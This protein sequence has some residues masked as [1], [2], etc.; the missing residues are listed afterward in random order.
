MINLNNLKVFF[1]ADV[2]QP[3]TEQDIPDQLV[4]RLTEERYVNS[5]ICIEI[6]KIHSLFS[7]VKNTK[8]MLLNF[9]G[10]KKKKKTLNFLSNMGFFFFL[11]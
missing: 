9:V 10:L 8:I 7:I 11:L 5:V 1:L 4:E 6:I 3:V 2:L